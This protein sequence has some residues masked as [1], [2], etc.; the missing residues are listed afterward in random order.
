MGELM[1]LDVWLYGDLKKYGGEIKK[2]GVAHLTVD[3]ETGRCLQD[4][5][6]RLELPT[7]ERG[8]TFVNGQLSALPGLQPDLK[9]ELKDADRVALF[10]LKS[11]WPFQYR[12]GATMTGEMRQLLASDPEAIMHHTHESVDE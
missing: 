2:M 11:M 8:I 9:M 1:H 4:L 3:L 10:D 7:R 5:L 6:D 12:H